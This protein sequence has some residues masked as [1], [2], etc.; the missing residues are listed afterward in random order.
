MEKA[1]IALIAASVP[2]VGAAAGWLK[3]ETEKRE[4]LE[5]ADN[6][7]SYVRDQMREQEQAAAMA[8]ALDRCMERLA[9]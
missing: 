6:Y 8:R 1:L 4:K 3:A 9:E 5:L 7:G 2:L